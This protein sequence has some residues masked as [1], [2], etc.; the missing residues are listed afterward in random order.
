MLDKLLSTISDVPVI[1][2]GALGSALFALILYVGQRISSYVKSE[3]TSHS[4]SRRK[5]YLIEERIKYNVLMTNKYDERAAYVSLLLYR[6]S[7]S[8]V[9][10]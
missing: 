9:R 10:R 2:Q 6:A 7:R 4:R 3:A 8:L 1:V 5:S